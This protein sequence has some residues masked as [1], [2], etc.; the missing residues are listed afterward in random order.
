MK[1]EW[2]N[3]H[4]LSIIHISK[5]PLLKSMS[6]LAIE[7]YIYLPVN[8]FTLTYNVKSE[9]MKQLLIKA[10]VDNSKIIVNS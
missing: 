8:F 6:I 1:E 3:F 7:V 2:L 10:G 4:I 9:A 5:P